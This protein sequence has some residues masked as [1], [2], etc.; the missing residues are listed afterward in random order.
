MCPTY[1]HI[2]ETK[3]RIPAANLAYASSIL[4]VCI[5]PGAALAGMS[6]PWS[7]NQN[8]QRIM[9]GWWG[10]SQWSLIRN[11]RNKSNC[12]LFSCSLAILTFTILVACWYEF[13]RVV[14]F[15]WQMELPHGMS[16]YRM[17][18]KTKKTDLSRCICISRSCIT[19]K[20]IQWRCMMQGDPANQS[21]RCTD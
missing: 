18:C 21:T 13:S 8:V 15:D 7:Q 11:C 20:D 9:L 17:H 16:T 3:G 10:K 14:S 2:E 12:S 1:S 5:K 6:R 4:Q 19:N